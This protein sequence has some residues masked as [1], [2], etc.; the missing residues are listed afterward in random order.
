[1]V[2][3]VYPPYTLS[4]PTTKKKHFF[5]VCLP[6]EYTVSILIYG[7]NS[8]NYKSLFVMYLRINQFAFLKTQL[9]CLRRENT[10]IQKFKSFIRKS[11]CKKV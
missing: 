11:E 1:M 7:Q 8:S 4:G 3:G 2:R 6:L 10:L 9:L 5:Y